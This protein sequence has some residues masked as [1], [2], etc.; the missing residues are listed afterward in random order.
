MGQGAMRSQ[1]KKVRP[2][3]IQG[4]GMK[5]DKAEKLW[6]H[7]GRRFFASAEKTWKEIYNSKIKM[8]VIYNKWGKWI[9]TKGKEIKI[10]EGKK[11]FHSVMGKW[12]KQVRHQR[13]KQTI[14][15]TKRGRRWRVGITL[16]QVTRGR[17]WVGE[18][19]C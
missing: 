13:R 4:E 6:N 10:G 2:L 18:L 17:V 1:E 3:F 12:S 14:L 5:R 8:K 19:D 11:T 9:T 7:D 16:I 15:M